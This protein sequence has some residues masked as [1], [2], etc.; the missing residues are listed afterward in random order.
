MKKFTTKAAALLLFLALGFY[1]A[2]A[3]I[4]SNSGELDWSSANSWNLGRVPVCGDVIVIAK[5]STV[6]VNNSVNFTSGD[7]C[8][9][10]QLTIW[11]KLQFSS[12]KKITLHE[13]A[14][15]SIFSPGEIHP[16]KNGGG[17]SETI[18]IGK[19]IF[20]KAGDGTMKGKALNMSESG[21]SVKRLFDDEFERVMQ[22]FTLAQAELGGT[23][24]SNGKVKIVVAPNS[25]KTQLGQPVTGTVNVELI[26]LQ[27]RSGMLMMN[28]PTIALKADGNK[29]QLITGGE[30]YLRISQNDADLVAEIPVKMAVVVDNPDDRMSLFDGVTDSQ[31]NLSWTGSKDD[32]S[33]ENIDFK[34]S[35]KTAYTFPVG[36]WG[37]TNLDRFMNDPREKKKIAAKLPS[38]F[39]ASNTV[40][41]IAFKDGTASVSQLDQFENG[42]FTEH[43]GLIPIGAEIIVLSLSNYNGGWLYGVQ[44]V[45][46]GNDTELITIETLSPVST[47]SLTEIL[48]EL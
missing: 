38:G 42:H 45:V 34:G 4:I 29:T 1:A 36:T 16:S 26:E 39:D 7:F 27:K 18:E 8:D 17:N 48:N 14:G 43:Y 15:V 40:V 33:I 35:L 47:F 11:G 21:G 31:N 20:W 6:K 12:G 3:E 22:R 13:K 10:T 19:T 28:K 41:L 30:F 44:Q 9:R 5:G 25:L 32:L 37:W 2:A 46:V 24:Y 23:L